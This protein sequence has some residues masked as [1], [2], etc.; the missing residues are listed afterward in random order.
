[1]HKVRNLRIVFPLF[2]A[3]FFLIGL[4][5]QTITSTPTSVPTPFPQTSTIP[6][7]QAPLYQQVTLTAVASSENGA[8]PDFSI[9]TQTPS[10]TG[11]DDPRVTA[12]NAEMVDIVNKAIADFKN[13]L[14]DLSPTP[15]SSPSTFDLRYSLVSPPGDIFSIKFEMEGYVAGAAHPYHLSQTVNYDL[16][17]G[18][19]LALADLFVPG[20]DYLS[21]L[22]K[23]CTDQLSQRDIGFEGF[24]LGATA[25]P[26]NYRIWNITAD[27]LMITFDEYQVAPYAAG[28]QTVII[29]YGDLG[30]LIQYQGPLTPY[31]P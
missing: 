21:V 16:E 5:C 6:A 31:L 2:F 11:S 15:I 25:M 24:E 4:A 8:N 1:M 10:L 27:G 30:Q 20:S 22:A 29:P 3:G 9:T 23:Y 14:V 19:D 18:K 17:H 12:F 28:P 26:E 13:N 7:A